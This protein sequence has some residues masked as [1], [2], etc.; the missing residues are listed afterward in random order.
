MLHKK[1]FQF[2]DVSSCDPMERSC[3]TTKM[4]YASANDHRLGCMAALVNNSLTRVTFLSN[5][6]LVFNA[7]NFMHSLY[8]Y[9]FVYTFPFVLEVQREIFLQMKFWGFIVLNVLFLS[10]SGFTLVLLIQSESHEKKY[11][12]HC[13]LRNLNDDCKFCKTLKN[14]GLLLKFTVI[15]IKN[16]FFAAS[17]FKRMLDAWW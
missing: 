4:C 13:M 17:D 16:W 3:P 7:V 10:L 2:Y 12:I 1:I 5:F 15:W 6:F 9:S 14:V 11:Q 8:I